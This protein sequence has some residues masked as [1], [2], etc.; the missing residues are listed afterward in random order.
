MRM[1]PRIPKQ[2][3]SF[4]SACLEALQ[5][6]GLGKHVSL[7]GA[8][9][10]ALY[11]EFR[12]TKDVDAWWTYESTEEEQQK[13]IEVME[14][15]LERFGKVKIRSFGDVVSLDLYHEGKVCFNFQVAKRSTLLRPTL[16]SPWNPVKLDA[17]D[18]LVASKM[19]ALVARGIPRD[20]LDIY[21]LCQQKICTTEKCWELWQEREKKRGVEN[22]EAGL[23]MKAMRMHL[24]RIEQMRPLDSIKDPDAKKRAKKLRE[25]FKNEFEP[26]KLR[27]D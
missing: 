24:N 5:K 4:A 1:K 25:W 15:T 12:A 17:F 6:T 21:E 27:L 22:L 14:N 18:D 9:G 2:I 20:F 23:A 3:N 16:S 13:V 10:L 11:H 7:G 19:A 26:G 8:F